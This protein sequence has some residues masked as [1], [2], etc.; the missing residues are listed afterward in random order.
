MINAIQYIAHYIRL[1]QRHNALIAVHA[2]YSSDSE[3]AIIGIGTKK[4]CVCFKLRGSYVAMTTTINRSLNFNSVNN[5]LVTGS[6][7]E[8]YKTKIIDHDVKQFGKADKSKIYD[9]VGATVVAP[10]TYSK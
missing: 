2:S 5:I 10:E 3:F 1:I 4:R 7:P 9:A 8:T 6:C